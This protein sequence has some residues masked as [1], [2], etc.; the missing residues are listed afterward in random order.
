MRVF[1]TK[2]ALTKGIFT[3]ECDESEPNARGMLTYRE[4]GCHVFLHASDYVLSREAAVLEFERQRGKRITSLE[5]QL[6]TLRGA[7]PKITV[8]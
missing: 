1:V 5:K 8:G 3:V 7:T 2:Y 4:Q 6:A